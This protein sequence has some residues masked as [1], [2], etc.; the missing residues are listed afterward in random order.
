[1][2]TIFKQRKA[3]SLACK[4]IIISLF[5]FLYLSSISASTEGPLLEKAILPMA[6]N[7]VSVPSLPVTSKRTALLTVDEVCGKLAR[8]LGSVRLN[9]CLGRGFVSTGGVSVNG[10]PIIEKEYGPLPNREP[11]AKV[12]LI[13]GIHGDEYSS[14]SLVFKWMKI[15]DRNHSG[16]FHWKMVPVMNPDGLLRKKSQRM[17]ENGVDLNRNFPTP[18]WH[19]ESQKYWL[20]TSRNPRRYPGPSPLSE[21]ESQ[22]LADYIV[23]FQ[24]D[25]IVSIH[26]PYGILDF[27]GPRNAPKNFGH[28]HLNLLGTYPGSLGNYAGITKQIPVITIELPYAGIMPKRHEIRQIWIDLVSWLKKNTG[29]YRQ[30]ADQG[31]LPPDPTSSLVNNESTM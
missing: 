20:K 26:A 31:N 3:N 14:V 9:D 28:L 5:V 12:L 18:N 7:I 10:M 23:Q 15:L 8:K 11:K 30:Q 24:P 19:H 29:E 1:M 22:W 27:D 2:N 17:N 4:Q 16:L 13:G 6:P 25:V 21:P